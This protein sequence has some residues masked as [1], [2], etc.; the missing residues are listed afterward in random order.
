VSDVLALSGK[1]DGVLLVTNAKL[2]IRSEV[3]QAVRNLRQVDAKIIGA[4]LNQTRI[5]RAKYTRY[6]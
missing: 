2:S 6:D 4:V 3:V 1:V 5:S